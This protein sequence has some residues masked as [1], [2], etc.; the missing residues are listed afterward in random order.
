MDSGTTGQKVFDNGYTIPV[1]NKKVS[2]DAPRKI[3]KR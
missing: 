3:N 2:S 1:T